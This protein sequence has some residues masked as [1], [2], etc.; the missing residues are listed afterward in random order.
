MPGAQRGAVGAAG[1]EVPLGTGLHVV[2]RVDDPGA[3]GHVEARL[4][5][6]GER[7]EAHGGEGGGDERER[8]VEG[9]GGPVDFAEGLGGG[10]PDVRTVCDAGRDGLQRRGDAGGGRGAE[11]VV[12]GLD[13]A[14]EGE[15]RLAADVHLVPAAPVRT[16][17]VPDEAGPVGQDAGAVEGGV[18]DVRAAGAPGLV[19]DALPDARAVA[20]GIDVLEGARTRRHVHEEEL[21][22]L[23]GGGAVDGHFAPAGK[24]LEEGHHVVAQEEPAPVL[25]VHGVVEGAV[26]E[27]MGAGRA[28]VVVAGVLAAG[29]DAVLHGAAQHLRVVLGLLGPGGRGGDV[30]GRPGAGVLHEAGHVGVGQDAV[31]LRGELRRVEAREG[32]RED[33][34]LLEVLDAREEIGGGGGGVRILA[35][36]VDLREVERAEGV[37][38]D[39]L[40]ARGGE[41]GGVARVLEAALAPNREKNVR[42]HEHE[43]EEPQNHERKHEDNLS[44][45]GGIKWACGL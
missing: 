17:E 21:G 34:A 35:R 14:A 45:L 8:A 36:D 27:G 29:V 10:G 19:E 44:P 43:E 33:E 23:R 30:G 6:A 5:R 1:G 37:E 42:V 4:R 16:V 25:A 39:A 11:N 26:V 13:V 24:S 12:A 22:I 20:V 41:G 9:D 18:G 32:A 7:D 38:R 2:A 40:P 15:A 31:A 28:V 3:F